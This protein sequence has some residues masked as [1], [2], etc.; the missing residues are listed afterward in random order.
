MANKQHKSRWK[1]FWVISLLLA[2]AFLILIAVVM[3]KF[4]DYL[5]NMDDK[6]AARENARSELAVD[7]YMAKID[8]A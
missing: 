6:N 1:G 5:Q 4:S 3:G 2:L 7:A 8:G